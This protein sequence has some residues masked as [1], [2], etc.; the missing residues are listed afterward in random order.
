MAFA[1]IVFKGAKKETKSAEKITETPKKRLEQHTRTSIGANTV[2]VANYAPTELVDNI[3]E[4][5]DEANAWGCI[6]AVREAMSL[7]NCGCCGDPLKCDSVKNRH[8]RYLFFKARDALLEINMPFFKRIVRISSRTIPTKSAVTKADSM[9]S[10]IYAGIR[11]I[12]RYRCDHHSNADFKTF[13]YMR[14]K[15]EIVDEL[16]R[17]QDF[18]ISIAALR[19]LV[20]PRI[21]AI[22]HILGKFPTLEDLKDRLSEREFSACMNPLM[23]SQVHTNSLYDKEN[24]NI[25]TEETNNGITSNIRRLFGLR[26]AVTINSIDLN[27]ILNN[28]IKL[29]EVIFCYYYLGMECWEIAMLERVSPSTITKRKNKAEDL[30][31]EF[32]GTR[33]RM[34][35]AIYG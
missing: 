3:S 32:F 11:C 20:R 4:P 34:Y 24:A 35:E 21:E 26:E 10:A 14:V 6:Q 29:H 33:R 28:D 19:R 17:L 23:F 9:N 8:L 13:A 7:C 30:I 12:H 25:E 18:P 2:K 15:G 5:S 16:R 27:S 1:D 31:R 22:S